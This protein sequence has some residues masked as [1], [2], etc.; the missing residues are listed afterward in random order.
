MQVADT[1]SPRLC[2]SVRSDGS[3]FATGVNCW[4]K[5]HAVVPSSVWVP[6]RRDSLDSWAPTRSRSHG[7]G[8]EEED[9][10]AKNSK[11]ENGQTVHPFDEEES[12]AEEEYPFDEEES[13]AKEGYW[14]Q[15]K[16]CQEKN[17]CQAVD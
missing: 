11:E 17:N 2:W 1:V 9:G 14:G 10:K 3:W 7:N 8:N 4:L 6:R 16:N 5:A 12:F 13:F 15:E